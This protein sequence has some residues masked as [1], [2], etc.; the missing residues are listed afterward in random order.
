MHIRPVLPGL[1]LAAL[2]ACSGITFPV[3]VKGDTTLPGDPSPLPGLLDA[4]PAIGNFTHLDFDNAQEFKNQGVTKDQVESVKVQS[5]RL[6]IVSP[7]D[8]DYAFLD[9]LEVYAQAGERQVL[10]AERSG[11]HALG[12]KAP[13]PVLELQVKDVELAPY[14]TA[15]SMSLSVRG[16]GRLPAQDTRLEATVRL[17][18][19]ADLW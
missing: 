5:I 10:V 12:L 14:V 2:T 11:I 9:T 16:K 3:E 6:T 4:F 19:T 13:H 8:Q 15:P 18:V 17:Q 7:D 1:C